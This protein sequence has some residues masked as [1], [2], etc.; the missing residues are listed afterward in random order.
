MQIGFGAHRRRAGEEATAFESVLAL[1]VLNLA[2]TAQFDATNKRKLCYDV[3]TAPP[4]HKGG[5]GGCVRKSGMFIPRTAAD[6]R[7]VLKIYC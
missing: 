4:H 3:H 2:T 7:L 1:L 5:E 6:A